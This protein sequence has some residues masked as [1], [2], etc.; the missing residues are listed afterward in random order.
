MAAYSSAAVDAMVGNRQLAWSGAR[1]RTQQVGAMN[2]EG[3]KQAFQQ[4]PRAQQLDLLAEMAD[5]LE[6]SATGPALSE[7]ERAEL[8]ARFDRYRRAPA[9][10]LT[11]L[12]IRNR[13]ERG[14]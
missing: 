5:T 3:I 7:P 11:M 4:L 8:L 14:Q 6:A 1:S 13:V 9:T 2:V 12:Q 10:A